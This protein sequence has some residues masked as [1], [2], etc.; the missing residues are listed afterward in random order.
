MITQERRLSLDDVETLIQKVGCKTP[1]NRDTMVIAYVNSSGYHSQSAC[2]EDGTL[3]VTMTLYEAWLT[4]WA[5]CAWCEGVEGYAPGRDILA[6]SALLD[7]ML[8]QETTWDD[9]VRDDGFLWRDFNRDLRDL[10]D[11]AREAHERRRQSVTSESDLLDVW[12]VF[13]APVISYNVRGCDTAALATWVR[14]V[15]NP[16]RKNHNLRSDFENQLREHIRYGRWVWGVWLS[17]ASIDTRGSRIRC[18]SHETRRLDSSAY[19]ISYGFVPECFIDGLNYSG[20]VALA[21][22]SERGAQLAYM[23]YQPPKKPRN[24]GSKRDLAALRD[25]LMGCKA[26]VAR[27]TES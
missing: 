3:E 22:L 6:A 23:M 25:T 1:W 4:E 12:G 14:E 10:H 13:C 11:C 20:R 19:T 16:E 2:V 21:G 18:V 26:L 24:S 7:V 8:R 17:P 15:T 27:N 9:L 5:E